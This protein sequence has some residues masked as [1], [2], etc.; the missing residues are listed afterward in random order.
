MNTRGWRRAIN[1]PACA[2]RGSAAA[3]VPNWK[4]RMM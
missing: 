3:T 1:R 2:A 4:L